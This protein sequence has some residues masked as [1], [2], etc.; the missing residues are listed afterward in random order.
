MAKRTTK[1]AAKRQGTKT[2][3]KKGGK[4]EAA[5]KRT[6]GTGGVRTSNPMTGRCEPRRKGNR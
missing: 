3:S 5:P 4:Q 1:K 6:A 2:R